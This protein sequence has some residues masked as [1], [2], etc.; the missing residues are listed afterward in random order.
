MWYVILLAAT[1]DP[2]GVDGRSNDYGTSAVWLGLLGALV[3]TALAEARAGDW[4]ARLFVAAAIGTAIGAVTLFS[5]MTSTEHGLAFALG[6]GLA[7][8]R[9]LR[10]RGR[11]SARSAAARE[12][13]PA[14]PA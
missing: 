13:V 7:T 12:Y 6:A 4:L 2:D 5:L 1:G 3:V 11:R 8:L 14:E 10:R 9:E